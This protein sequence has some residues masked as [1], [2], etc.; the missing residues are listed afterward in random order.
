MQV[1]MRECTS[2]LNQAEFIRHNKCLWQWQNDD[3]AEY[4]LDIRD[5]V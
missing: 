3:K 5:L 1:M 4:I 2:P